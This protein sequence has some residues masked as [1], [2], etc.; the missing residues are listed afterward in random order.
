MHA[1]SK[2]C[3]LEEA[4]HKQQADRGLVHVA[5]LLRGDSQLT[6]LEYKV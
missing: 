3:S 5:T 4:G 6:R 2:G 1:V